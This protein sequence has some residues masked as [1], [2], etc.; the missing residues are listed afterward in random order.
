MGQNLQLITYNRMI[1]QQMNRSKVV[2]HK[3]K[4]KTRLGQSW[5]WS[6]APSLGLAA[7]VSQVSQL[8]I[9]LLLFIKCYFRYLRKRN[10]VG[11]F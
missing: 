9:S 4:N 8:P 3:C 1:A 7:R 5:S 10:R 2:L 6:C 11:T